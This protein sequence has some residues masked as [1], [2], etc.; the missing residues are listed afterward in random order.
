[1]HK[2]KLFIKAATLVCALAF[3]HQAQANLPQDIFEDHKVELLEY[4]YPAKLGDSFSCGFY[5]SWVA[6]TRN[7]GVVVKC[8]TAQGTKRLYV[9][10][11]GK[12]Y[13][14]M[15]FGHGD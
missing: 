12:P 13:W 7:A 9:P 10:L 5:G 3:G 15:E 4:D 2:R 14:L 1:M 6:A 11:K 8:P